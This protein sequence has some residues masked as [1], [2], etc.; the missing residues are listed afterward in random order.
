MNE[1]NDPPQFAWASQNIVAAVMLLSDIPEP[2]DPQE[3]EVYRNLRVLV[4]A[5]DVQQAE[6][7]AS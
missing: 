7:S 2:V 1:G 3:R 5:V 6:S 4:E